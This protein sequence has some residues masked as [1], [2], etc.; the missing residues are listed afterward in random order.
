M[1]RANSA[2]AGVKSCTLH[3]LFAIL[4]LLFCTAL[5]AVADVAGQKRVLILNSYHQWYKGSDSAVEGFY[6][7][8][9]KSLPLTEVQ[10]EYL[11]SK[12][13]TGKEF[14]EKVLDLLRF[15]YQQRHFDLI[16]STDDYAF[17][18]LEKYRD[19]IFGQEPVLFCGTNCFD[20]SRLNGK[21]NF[22]GL[23]ERP[24]FADTLELILRLHP[25]TNEVVVVHDDS[26]TGE[27][28]SAEFRR[29]TASFNNRI[30]F[31]YLKGK[32]VDEVSRQL[33][34]LPPTAVVIYF[35]SFM[36]DRGGER[37]SSNHA[38]QRLAAATPVPIYGG[39]GFSLGN[40]IVGGRL[41]DLHEHGVVM[42]QMAVKILGGASPASLVNL[43]PGP[44]VYMFDYAQMSRFGVKESQLPPGSIIINRPDTFWES[45]RMTILGFLCG[46]LFLALVASF[47]KLLRSRRELA[48]SLVEQQQISRSLVRSEARFRNVVEAMPDMVYR[49]TTKRGGIYYSPRVIDILGYTPEEL[50]ARPMLW[51][52]SI[53]PEDA[54]VVDRALQQFMAGEQ[55]DIVY[56]LTDRDG[57]LHW[58]NDRSISMH[59]EGDEIIFEGIAADITKRK[60]AEEVLRL[61]EEKL[62]KVFNT[63][64]D[65]L[66]LT[67]LTDGLILEV[68]PSYLSM[69]GYSREEVVGKTT[70]EIDLWIDPGLR[71]EMTRQIRENG[72]AVNME[73]SFKRKD[74]SILE[75][76]LSARPID[77]FGERC[78]LVAARDISE[79][80]LLEEKLRQSLKMESIGRLAGGV[81]HDFNNKLTV[82]LAYSEMA[83]LEVPQE[84]RLWRYLNE[85]FKAAEHSRDLTAQLLAFSRQ[86]VI[87]PKEMDLNAFIRDGQ[88]TLP[89]LIG[90][91][92]VVKYSLAGDLWKTK[93]DPTQ[94]D[95]IVMNLSINARDAMPA[96]GTLSI[97][98]ANTVIDEDF[99]EEQLDAKPGEYVRLT[100]SDTG[101]GMEKGTLK[102]IF[103]PFFTTKEIGKGTGLGLATVYGIITQNGGFIEVR[104]EPGRG[105]LF[106]IYLP[107]HH[108]ESA[109]QVE[110]IETPISG[111]GSIL[112]VEDDETV[113][114]MT[115]EML[116][117]IGY[118]VEA[119]KTPEEAIELCR[120]RN[121]VVDMILSDVIMPGMSGKE[122]SDAIRKIRPAIKVVFMSGYTFETISSKGLVQEGMQLIQKP[123]DLNTLSKTVKGALA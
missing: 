19:S 122:M 69:S 37:L 34:Q 80:K 23:D 68:N 112:L 105:T 56:R 20:P 114:A 35:A 94:L 83:L 14:D 26:V 9:M 43:S 13:F 55:F 21:R 28:N 58:I 53:H 10:I 42:A 59:A 61:S 22:N 93:I 32:K 31:S 41:L 82:I 45:N 72:E 87:S 84:Q 49:W 62:F 63:S 75:T 96:G 64:P 116:E 4:F 104:S 88:R 44:N 108:T 15:K 121:R 17:N 38:L 40:G 24:S 67:R 74:G 77:V 54:G 85:I 100:F 3:I 8:L 78:L 70:L 76:L 29:Q 86:Q 110:E 2:A 95:Q 92:I 117:R 91:D 101:H 73:V 39:W 106:H 12:H 50:Y 65:A 98:T 47:L 118:R 102:H 36:E 81:A 119:P 51:R 66:S 46:A 111:S 71:G 18:I 11:D 48:A 16:F 79:R 120:D 113:R 7:T 5:P 123:F 25:R 60:E 1:S 115:C 6:Q 109:G 57:E 107:R 89:R 52:D 103:E 27:L 97:I 30:R 99:C 33:A 90:E